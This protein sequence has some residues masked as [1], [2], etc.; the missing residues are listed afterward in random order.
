MNQRLLDVTA[1]TTLD[2]ADGHAYGPNW[3]DNAAA[4]VDVDT[5]QDGGIVTLSVELDPGSLEH[6]DPHADR[7][8]LTPEQARLL[9]AELKDAAFDAELDIDAPQNAE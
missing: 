9:A 5:P 2:I 6:V 1:F 4:V 3:Q 8:S 7:I